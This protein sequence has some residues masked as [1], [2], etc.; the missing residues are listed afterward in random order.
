MINKFA[1]NVNGNDLIDEMQVE[2]EFVDE[3]EN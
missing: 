1:K 3:T 2:E